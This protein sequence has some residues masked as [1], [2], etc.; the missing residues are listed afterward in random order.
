MVSIT[1]SE[2]ASFFEDGDDKGNLARLKAL[3]GVTGVGE[4]LSTSLKE[5]LEGV[6]VDLDN[7]AKEFGAN[8]F[9]EPPSQSWMDMFLESFEDTTLIILIVSAVVSFAVGFYEDPAK[10]WIEGAAIL[11]A[12]LIVA[13]VTASNN[14]S[15]ELQFRKLNAQKDDVNVGVVRGGKV[16]SIDIK[17]LVVGD[18]VV[19]NSGDKIPADGLLIR[20]SDVTVNESALTGEPEDVTKSLDNDVFLMSGTALSTGY[21]HMLVVAVG[22]QSRWGKTKAMLATETV[23]TPLQEKLDVLAGQ[24]GNFGIASAVLTFIAMLT[25]WILY[26]ES[27]E[28]GVNIFEYS[29]KAFIMGV[30]IVVVAVPEGLPLAVTLSLAF[31]TQKMMADNNLI[32]VLAA[33]E[34]MGNATNI[35]SDKTGTLTQNRMTVVSGWLAGSRKELKNDRA[36]AEILQEDLVELLCE[37]ISVNT[38]A[39]LLRSPGEVPTVNGSK[40]EGALLMMI[41]GQFG[42]DYVPMRNRFDVSRGDR[43]ITFSSDRKRMTSVLVGGSE[44]N[45]ISY[46]KG[47]AEI[48]LE[49]CTKY[50]DAKGRECTLT[51]KIREEVLKCIGDMAVE[52]LRCIALAHKTVTLEN[53]EGVDP[54][55][56]ES[57]MVLDAICGIKDPLRPDVPEAVKACQEAGV[58]VRMVTGDNIETAK[59]IAK[60][61]GILTEGGVSMEGPEFRKLTPA[62]LDVILP[63]LQV[64]ARSSPD[65]KFLLV[66]RLNGGNLPEDK[67]AWEERHPSAVWATDKDLLLPGYRSEWEASRADGGEVVGVTGDGTN[68]APA[69][70]AADVGLS[71]G[72]SGTDVAK[73]ASDIVILDDNFSS[74]VKSVMWGRSVFDNIRKFLQFQLTVNVV[75]LMLTF[76]SAVLGKPPPLNAVMMLWV[77]MIMDTMGALALGTEP[78]S[79]NLLKRLPYKRNASLINNKMLR[80]IF[81]QFVFQM[82]LLVY[83]S[84]EAAPHFQTVQ[85]STQHIT[86]VFNTFVFCQVFNEINA[87]SIDDNMNVFKGMF[88]N[89]L[90]IAIILFTAGA[91]YGIVE[92]GGDFV[93]TVSLSNDQWVKSVCLASLT[94]PLGGLMRLIPVQD[95]DKDFAQMSPLMSK[96][97]EATHPSKAVDSGYSTSFFLWLAVVGVLP[98]LCWQQFAEHWMPHIE[99]AIAMLKA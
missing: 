10:G 13:V 20:G 90:F 34:T 3:G 73:E 80:H 32:R 58:F 52:S 82:S 19:L 25:I 88:A 4:K 11:A 94:L 46:T 55:E 68:D 86:I 27:R 67:A 53:V 65:D 83:L 31:S 76:L 15:K 57:G 96:N 50:S 30:T 35:C 6:S 66:T 9:P 62:Q 92:Y 12:V 97:R 26:P 33:C 51:K 54:E 2:V 69:L 79:P 85:D 22:E 14:Y 38:T 89:P 43:M 29:L 74:I 93:R 1:V 24:I 48:V 91:Q 5:G 41:K 75:A 44:G 84:Y 59:A 23:Q 81:V 61:C 60:E 98:M 49:R 87:R 78:P 70:K 72:L 95:S 39:D 17:A 47:A 63:N 18:I 36:L 56:F 21:C 99:V 71:M 40:T 16:D 7:R 64:L 45:G 42:E 8:K 77:N 28:E 37:G